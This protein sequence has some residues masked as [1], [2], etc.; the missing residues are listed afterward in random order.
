VWQG[1]AF[2]CPQSSDEIA[3]RH[4]QFL[5]SVGVCNDGA[6]CA[7]ADSI[8]SQSSFVSNLIV[9]ITPEL[10]G[11]KVRCEHDDGIAVVL[12]GSFTLNIT[13]SELCIYIL[14]PK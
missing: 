5:G 6:I 8:S 3:L 11:R 1:S 9:Y 2:Q 10:E 4:A 13:R 12:V 7:H 14:N